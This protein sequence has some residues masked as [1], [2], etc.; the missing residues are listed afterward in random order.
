M[1]WEYADAELQCLCEDCHETETMWRVRLNEALARL[2]PDATQQVVGFAEGHMLI[3][4]GVE[5]GANDQPLN[6]VSIDEAEGM[7]AVLS[8]SV[9]RAYEFLDQ[10]RGDAR[11]GYTISAK[12]FYTLFCER[13]KRARRSDE[14]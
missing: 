8:R 2:R 9:M 1:P 6:I 3:D 11:S 12:A 5:Q 7:E 13:I 14:S 10:C 4:I